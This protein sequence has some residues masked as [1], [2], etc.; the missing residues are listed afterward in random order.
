M[1][2]SSD[3]PGAAALVAAATGRA[4]A[5]YTALTTPGADPIGVPTEVVL[6]PAP[7]RGWDEDLLRDLDRFRAL[8]L[9]P[10]LGRSE[11]TM[12]AVRNLVARAELPVVVDADALAAFAADGTG[13]DPPRRAP[14]TST[15]AGAVVDELGAHRTLRSSSWSA[16]SWAAR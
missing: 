5:G 4:G 11:A 16:S 3:M 7:A 13:G 10:G 1:A 6:R 8:A 12:A 2:G 9:G 14:C 15:S